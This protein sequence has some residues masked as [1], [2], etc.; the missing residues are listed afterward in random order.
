MES[1]PIP[2]PYHSPLKDLHFKRLIVDEGHTFGNSSSSS[3]TEAVSVVEFLQLSARWIVSGTPTQGLYG[4]EVAIGHSEDSSYSV[5]PLEDNDLEN[6]SLLTKAFPHLS[7]RSDTDSLS[8]TSK[9]R[10]AMFL[11]AGTQRLG[12]AW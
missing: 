7:D 1:G 6:S 5:T 8:E 4:V 9:K 10:E 12:K 11:Q 2:V 3:K